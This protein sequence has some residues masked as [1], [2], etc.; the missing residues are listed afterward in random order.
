M[1]TWGVGLYSSDDA[2]ELR[3]SIR[4]VCR[5]PHSG[6]ELVEL[7]AELNP[8]TRDPDNEGHATFWLVVADQLQRRGIPS[9]ARKRA[10]E[11]IA[12]GTDLA[13]LAKLGMTDADLKKRKNLLES[14]ADELRSPPPEKPRK[15]LKQP[16]PLLF[17]AGDVLVY[18]IDDQGN[19]CNPYL[20][21]PLRASFKPVGWDGCVIVAS[22]L[23][24]EYLAWYQI[25]PTRAPW[26]DRPTLVQIVARSDSARARVGTM[27]KSHVAR[28]GLEL[29]GTSMPPKLEPPSKELLVS[30]TAQDISAGNVLGRWLR[31]GTLQME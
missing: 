20:T 18:R 29:L 26:K 5:L 8:E 16:Q 23:A 11:I 15:T 24:L 27:S 4:G 17:R 13:M 10:L 3:A 9:V 14:L 30:T 1:G 22:G 7:L 12:D 2:L 28:M 31:P 25:A 19:C 6:D 21:G